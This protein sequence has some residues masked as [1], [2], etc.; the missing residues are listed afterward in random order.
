M[1]SALRNY[2]PV[3]T[4]LSSAISHSPIESAD[5][6]FFKSKSQCI[7]SD[8]NALKAENAEKKDSNNESFIFYSYS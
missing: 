6:S 2:T 7:D 1:K 5:P 4:P 8:Q 3:N